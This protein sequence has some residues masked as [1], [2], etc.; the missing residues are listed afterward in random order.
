M[1]DRKENFMHF[2]NHEPHDHIPCTADFCM[3]GGNMELFENGPLGG[4]ADEFGCIWDA[5]D[6]AMGQGVPAPG[7]KYISDVTDWKNQV[8]FPDPSKYDWQAQADAQMPA[9]NPETQVLDYG[10][11]NGQFLR[12]MHL[13]GFDN[14][15]L[16]L[17]MEPEACS[18][19]MGAIT[20]YRIST[21][22]YIKKY[23]NPD[24][25]TIYDDVATTANL[26]MSP[27][28]YRELIAPHHKKWFAA[29][30]EQGMI[31]SMHICGKC[32]SIIPDLPG[33]GTEMW[34]ICEITNDLVGL[35]KKV[36]DKLAFFGGYPM[37]G[38]FSYTD[39]TEEELRQSVR[40]TIDKYGPA[41]NYGFFGLIMY[42]DPQRTFNTMMTL[43]DEAIKYGTN[44][45]V[46]GPGSA[47]STVESVKVSNIWQESGVSK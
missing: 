47:A 32:E 45:Y 44:Y 17:A 36:G 43:T 12:L 29:V 9:Y 11:W 37:N 15:L 18:E 8:H 39:P 24:I 46:D 13:L 1:M 5:T 4:G 23:F 6:S 33:E 21:L 2:I 10:C 41:G 34:E 3:V 20:D 38:K 31:P 19:F 26:F 35:Q 22:P 14:G 16:A 27:N 30:R 25:V 28:T 42:A 7:Q 40:D